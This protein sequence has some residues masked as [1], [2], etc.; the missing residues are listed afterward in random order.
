MVFVNNSPMIKPEKNSLEVC[1]ERIRLESGF[2]DDNCV[3]LFASFFFHFKFIFALIGNGSLH[4]FA[5]A[6]VFQTNIL[7]CIASL[8]LLLRLLLFGIN[9]RHE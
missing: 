9:A 6:N 4:L 7:M 1:C 3:C 2:W 5:T 8:L